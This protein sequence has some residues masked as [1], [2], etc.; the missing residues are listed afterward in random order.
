VIDLRYVNGH[1]RVETGA[2]AGLELDHYL[3]RLLSIG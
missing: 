1:G 2:T 3:T